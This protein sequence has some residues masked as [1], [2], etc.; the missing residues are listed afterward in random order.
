LCWLSIKD[1][2]KVGAK[3]SIAVCGLV[4]F[5]KAHGF[6]VRMWEGMGEI[7]NFFSGSSWLEMVE[8]WFMVRGHVEL[9]LRQIR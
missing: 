4:V 6:S 9:E 8:P 3:C 2:K 1:K 5:L 7:K